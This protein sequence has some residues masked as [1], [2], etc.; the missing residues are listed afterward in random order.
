MSLEGNHSDMV[1]FLESDRNGYEKIC[2][3]LKD[4][5]KVAPSIIK[6]RKDSFEGNE[7]RIV[8]LFVSSEAYITSYSTPIAREAK[9][10]HKRSERYALPCI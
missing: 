7:L 8:P 4:F 1:K 9:R 10:V 2:K 6:A 5:I 3:V